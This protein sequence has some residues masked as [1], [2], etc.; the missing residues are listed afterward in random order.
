MEEI[1]ETTNT[2]FLTVA[3]RQ[4]CNGALA[5]P[6]DSSQNFPATPK[7]FAIDFALENTP[8]VKAYLMSP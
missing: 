8:Q 6:D 2:L 7:T 3:F 5:P 4:H 1:L